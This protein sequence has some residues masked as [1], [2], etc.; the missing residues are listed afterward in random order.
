MPYAIR[1]QGVGKRYKLGGV[2]ATSIRELLARLASFWKRMPADHVELE[3]IEEGHARRSDADKEGRF[4]ALDDVTFEVDQGEVLGIVGRNGSG[5]STLLKI[6]SQITVPTTGRVELD[7]RV[8]SLLEVG[9]GFHQELSGRENVFL[10]GAIL[11]MHPSEI[12]RKFDDIVAFAEVEKFIDT[13]VKRYSTGMYMRLAFA[14]AAHLEPEIL[15]VDEVLAVGDG[16]FQQK[17]LGKMG[18]VAH[19]GRTVLFV[20]HNALAVRSLCTHVLWLD[21]GRVKGYGD[22]Q[23]ILDKYVAS[24]LHGTLGG[25]IQEWPSPLDAPGAGPIRLARVAIAPSSFSS[26]GFLT[27]SNDVGMEVEYW[28]LRSGSKIVLNSEVYTADGVPVFESFTSH[29]HHWHGREAPAGR[30]RYSFRIP[31]HLLNEGAYRLRLVFLDA[32]ARTVYNH[33]SALYFTVHDDQERP[34]PFFGKWQGIVRP[35]IEWQWDYL[36]EDRAVTDHAALVSAQSLE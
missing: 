27:V 25:S 16:S 23:A 26:E 5:K 20:S 2:H 21:H 13:P 3:D 30:F 9:T 8:A 36:G 33:P 28:N 1:A 7:G 19:S 10:N 34:L 14:V 29:D 15:L 32:T 12:R 24:T 22:T 4:W 17:C 6:L 11:G 18:E 31:G 35:R